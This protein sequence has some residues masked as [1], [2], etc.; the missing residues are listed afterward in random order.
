M[1]THAVSM[2]KAREVRKRIIEE[3]GMSRARERDRETGTAAPQGRA[4]LRR[5]ESRI[6]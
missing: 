2:E 3:E 5:V 4:L 1:D 6:R